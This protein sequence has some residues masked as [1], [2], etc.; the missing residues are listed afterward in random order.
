[1]QN[2]EFMDQPEEKLKSAESDTPRTDAFVDSQS[3]EQFYGGTGENIASMVW[4]HY[5]SL[6]SHARQLERELNDCKRERDHFQRANARHLLHHIESIC[7]EC[8]HMKGEDGCPNCIAKDRDSIRDALQE[9]TD[10][11]RECAAILCDLYGT[12]GPL[13]KIHTDYLLRMNRALSKPSTREVL[14]ESKGVEG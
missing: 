11:H 1:M 6:Q 8:A 4:G 10:R 9:Q 3:Q 7:E 14:K 5:L 2:E 12:E 13:P